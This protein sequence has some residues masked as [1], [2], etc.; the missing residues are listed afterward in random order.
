MQY[1]TPAGSG[2]R[3]YSQFVADVSGAPLRSPQSPFVANTPRFGCHSQLPT[4]AYRDLSQ[5]MVTCFL[6]CYLPATA[7]TS[8]V[9]LSRPLHL[10][11][12]E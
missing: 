7:W 4:D 11:T 3:K 6:A 5:H 12:I 2:I 10:G 8:I 1:F 9:H